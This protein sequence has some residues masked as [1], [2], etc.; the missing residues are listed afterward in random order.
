MKKYERSEL[1]TWGTSELVEYI[2]ELQNKQNKEN[3]NTWPVELIAELQDLA[4]TIDPSDVELLQWAGVPEQ[5]EYGFG[6]YLEG[7]LS[8]CC[9]ARITE[10][11]FCEQCGEHAI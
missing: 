9:D 1:F 2:T 3:N 7:V 11:G 8:Y 4:G 10:T 6:E 5:A